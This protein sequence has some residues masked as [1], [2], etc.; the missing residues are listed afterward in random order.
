MADNENRYKV[1]DFCF[2]CGELLSLLPPALCLLPPLGIVIAKQL[3][4]KSSAPLRVML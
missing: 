3:T 4:N 2:A 1:M